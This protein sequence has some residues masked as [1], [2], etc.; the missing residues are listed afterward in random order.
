MG[1]DQEADIL[2]PFHPKVRALDAT[3]GKFVDEQNCLLLVAC[4]LDV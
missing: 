2:Y 3:G 4:L 1:E